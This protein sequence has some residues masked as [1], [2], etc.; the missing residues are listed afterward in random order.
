[1]LLNFLE[2]LRAVTVF[3]ALL[4]EG[5][6]GIDSGNVEKLVVDR[7]LGVSKVNI[8]RFFQEFRLS[9]SLREEDRRFNRI[10]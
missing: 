7:S 4:F 2:S 6:F 1:M 8:Q 9:E 10:S 5:V 3:F